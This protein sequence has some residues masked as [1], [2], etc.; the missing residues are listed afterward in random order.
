MTTLRAIPERD[1]YR[2]LLDPL[3]GLPKR[4][5]L[6]DRLLTALA[7]ASRQN[8]FVGLLSISVEFDALRS[9]QAK[10]HAIHNVAVRLTSMLRPDDTAARLEDSSSFVVVCNFLAEEDDLETIAT[11]IK[12]GLGAPLAFDTEPIQVVVVITTLLACNGDNPDVLLGDATRAA[13]AH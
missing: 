1:D 10:V 6:H 11:R 5:L 12:A 13:L 9:N 3:T 7:R 4:A 8:R 2:S